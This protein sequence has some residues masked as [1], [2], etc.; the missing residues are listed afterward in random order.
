MLG[1]ILELPLR[2]LGTQQLEMPPQKGEHR[3][4]DALRRALGFAP[5][6]EHERWAG[7]GGGGGGGGN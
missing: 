2:I 5:P 6:G 1:L 4:V 7:E 3:L